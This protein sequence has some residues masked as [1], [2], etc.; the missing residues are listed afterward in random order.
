MLNLRVDGRTTKEAY[1]KE[2]LMMSRKFALSLLV[3]AVAAAMLSFTPI[4]AMA[5]T[6]QVNPMNDNGGVAYPTTV[7]INS[8]SAGQLERWVGLSPTM[9]QRIV[10]YRNE[11]GAFASLNDLLKVKGMS[12]QLLNSIKGKITVSKFY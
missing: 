11:H 6:S 1:A 3:T 4:T 10:S 2:N 8:A 5:T 12:P 7:S 9:A